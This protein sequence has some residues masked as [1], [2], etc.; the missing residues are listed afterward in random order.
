MSKSNYVRQER[1]RERAPFFLQE[2]KRN[3][4]AV[5]SD[6]VIVDYTHYTCVGIPSPVYSPSNRNSKLL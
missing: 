1:E 5:S 2:R 3:T 6:I 4:K